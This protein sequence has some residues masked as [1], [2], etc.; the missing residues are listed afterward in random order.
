MGL[1][2]LFLACGVVLAHYDQQILAE[3]NLQGDPLWASNVI[4]ARSV[5]FFYVVSGFLISFVL[6]TKYAPGPAGTRAFFWSRFLRIYPLWW[7][8][9]IAS[10]VLDPRWGGLHSPFEAVPLTALFG[11]DWLVS[12][13]AYP[14]AYWDF[15]PSSMGIAWTLAAELTFYAMAPW[16]LR[17]PRIA[18]SLFALSFVVRIAAYWFAGDQPTYVIWSFF[19]F[20]ATL[21]FFLLGY[22][23]Q[24]LGSRYPIGL[25]PSLIA[26]AMAALLSS[27]DIQV[28]VDL[29]ASYFSVICFAVA[30]PGLFAATKDSRFFNFCGDLTYPLYLIHSLMIVA[31]FWPWLATPMIALAREVPTPHLQSLA[32]F[33]ELL[34]TALVL[35]IAVHLLVERHLRWLFMAAAPRLAPAPVSESAR[36]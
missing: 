8:V 26:L 24:R 16:L 22:F 13:G 18:A 19:F 9:L 31:L 14:K 15:I 10:I 29:P 25:L 2:R 5:I 21:M 35:S 4:G 30:L 20:P 6:H 12:F 3:L 32:L 17:S 27:L 11:M 33:G 34:A 1:V 36:L 23:A 28:S 7:A